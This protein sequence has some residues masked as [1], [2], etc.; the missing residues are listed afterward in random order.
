MPSWTA[1]VLADAPLHDPIPPTPVPPSSPVSAQLAPELLVL[2]I[3]IVAVVGTWLWYRR[4]DRRLRAG[5]A[6][7]EEDLA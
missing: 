4:R 6:A 7:A 2:A 1:G 5:R 3:A